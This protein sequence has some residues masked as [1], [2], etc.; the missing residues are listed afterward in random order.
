M[1]FV[2]L[3]KKDRVWA[4]LRSRHPWAIGSAAALVLL[5]PLGHDSVEGPFVL[6]P[7]RTAVVRN[8]VGGSVTRVYASEGLS[9]QAGEPLVEL[10]NL[11]LQSESARTEADYEVASD[12]ANLAA[13]DYQDFGA[14]D[15]ERD[16]LAKQA[17]QLRREASDLDVLSPLSGVV[18]T[19]R[20]A[21]ILGSYAPEGTRLVEVADLG[22]MRARIFVSEHDL[23]KIA[24]GA[25][26]RLEVDGLWGKLDAAVTSLAPKS[27][28]IDPALAEA[29]QL[30]GLGTPNFYVAQM[31]VPNSDGRLKPGMVG[32]AR[33]YGRRRSWAGLIGQEAWRFFAR[34]LW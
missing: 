27:S 5:L 24:S 32:T 4:W 30:K 12:E 31:E 10:R 21:D 14:A 28:G 19:P 9:V 16:Q 22:R 25:R 29:N 2:Y 18:L 7:L 11:P 1:R 17:S 26:A 23:Y 33:I 13:L 20:V 3:D 34:K 6:E 8:A 15:Q